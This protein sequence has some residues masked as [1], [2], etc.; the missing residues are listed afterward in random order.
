MKKRHFALAILLVLSYSLNAFAVNSPIVD[1]APSTV[2][3]NFYTLTIYVEEGAKVTVVGGPS[4][5][6][7][8]TD[9]QGSDPED[10]QVEVMVGL[11]QNTVNTFSISAE[12]NGEISPSVVVTIKEATET[13]SEGGGDTTP[14]SAPDL[15]SIPEVVTEPTY[16]IT[17][18]TEKNANIYAY[19]SQGIVLA[20]TS[21]DDEGYFEVEVALEPDRTN[22]VNVTAEDEA[23][24]ESAASQAVIRKVGIGV[25]SEEDEEEAQ[26]P[27]LVTSSQQFFRDTE[28]HWA[29]D[30]INQLYEDKVVSGKSEGIFDPNGLITRAELTKI[31]ILAFGHS[32]NT[33]VDEHPFSDV[34]RNAWFA[35]YIEEAKRLDVVDGYPS[36]GFGPNDFITR[37][38]ALKIITE[39]AGFDV[40]SGVPI[41]DDVPPNAWF[42]PYVTFASNNNIVSGYD[43]GLFGPGDNIT[44]AAVAKIVVKTLELKNQ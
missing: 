38:A 6:A 15:D 10:G 5:I 13:S 23:G 19:S 31:A 42:T 40:M 43:N 4:N 34:P 3:A 33:T 12:K 8:V 22:R 17:G 44:R 9:G 11:S 30:Y 20:T 39:A 41:F 27:E 37:A 36:G 21:A 14:P 26:E 2:D 18:Q 7:P 1:S 28:S 35:P 25:S 29:E 24:N 32:V 16:T